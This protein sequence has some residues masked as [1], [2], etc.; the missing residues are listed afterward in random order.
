MTAAKQA[1]RRAVRAQEPREDEKRPPT[2]GWP[3]GVPRKAPDAPPPTPSPRTL[4][5]ARLREQ[6]LTL[7]E[8]GARLGA[9]G[10]PLSRQRVDQML[11]RAGISDARPWA[12]E[13]QIDAALD[14]ARTHSED[15]G[16]VMAAARV[17]LGG[18]G[19]RVSTRALSLRTTARWGKRYHL[20]PFGTPDHWRRC[21]LCKGWSAP[22][23][24]VG[25][26]CRPD[27]NARMREYL[28]QRHILAG[29]RTLDQIRARRA[30]ER[31]HTLAL[32][33][34]HGVEWVARFL[35]KAVSTIELRVAKARRERDQGAA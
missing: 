30:E 16:R 5:A 8:I 27:H 20:P 28:R 21:T 4:A 14:L 10:K 18:Q 15:R 1:P 11:K 31:Q 32:V 25:S 12:S 7:A 17:A 22:E 34:Q 23:D 2:R 3:K 9:P 13:A 29:G 35:G 26:I 19:L 6:G 24:M 33:E